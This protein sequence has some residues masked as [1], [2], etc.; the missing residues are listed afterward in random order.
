MKKSNSI[1]TALLL[2]SSMSVSAAVQL[3]SSRIIFKEGQKEATLT[4]R[5][6]ASNQSF[7]V[8]T[9][10][11]DVNN[12][13]LTPSPF[14]L[15]PPLFKMTQNSSANLR[16]INS[17][18]Q[19]FAQDKET[20]FRLNILSIPSQTDA[21]GAKLVVNNRSIIKF[22]YRP[23]S[24]SNHDAALAYQKLQI[25]TDGKYL[26]LTNPTPY[27]VNIGQISLNGARLSANDLSAMGTV[28][29]SGTV[30]LPYNV[31]LRNVTLTAIGDR[32]ALLTPRSVQLP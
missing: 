29:P 6:T 9:W 1:L 4:M 23:A 17:G 31:T 12:N 28:P 11:S 20:L 32:G 2:C 27:Y 15:T 5:N 25:K 21:E 26:T 3:S 14:L 18:R 8:Q 10:L 24:L 30:T 7:L 19:S 13:K 16:V 22:I